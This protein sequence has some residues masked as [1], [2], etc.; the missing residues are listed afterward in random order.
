[1]SL[2]IGC[3]QLT[4]ALMEILRRGLEV[5]K[6]TSIRLKNNDFVRESLEG[7]IRV[8]NTQSNMTDFIWENNFIGNIDDAN[9][10][11]ESIKQ[12]PS[13]NTIKFEDCFGE[14][15]NGYDMLCSLINGGKHFDSI[16]LVDNN[17]STMGNTHL[18]DYIATNPRL[19]TLHLE[20]AGLND[21][22]ATLMATA[23]RNNSNL[24][25]L[26]LQKNDVGVGAL[27]RAVFDPT[28]LNLVAECNHTCSIVM[29]AHFDEFQNNV[30]SRDA[31]SR[32]NK[33]KKIYHMISLRHKIGTNV[34]LLDAELGD[35]SLILVPHVL[36]CLYRCSEQFRVVHPRYVDDIRP[37][38]IF[39]EIWKG[40]HM[41]ALHETRKRRELISEVETSKYVD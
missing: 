20:N 5:T 29:R 8:I 16:T 33:G 28:S 9:L 15:L 34:K 38:S 32:Y 19:Q 1:M 30:F 4:P 37:L 41:P 23:L 10:L 31:N 2:F 40:W 21:N 27:E 7:I 24:R 36:D 26:H 35:D 17:V 12:H 3:I 39:F 14:Y 18:P 25:V 22:D 11:L 6:L 13:I